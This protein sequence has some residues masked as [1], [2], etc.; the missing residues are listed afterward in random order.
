MSQKGFAGN[1][2][3]MLNHSCEPNCY[4]RTIAVYSAG[5]MMQEHVVIFAKED[6]PPGTELT[7]NYRRELNRIARLKIAYTAEIRHA[8]LGLKDSSIAGC[9]R[10]I[11]N[12]CAEHGRRGRLVNQFTL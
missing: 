1:L 2:A 7:Y 3:H 12:A 10:Y 9:M 6:I 8:A 11:V 4:S 5:G